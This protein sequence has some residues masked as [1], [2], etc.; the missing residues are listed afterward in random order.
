SLSVPSSPQKS[1]KVN[2]FVRFLIACIRD[3]KQLD[4]VPSCLTAFP[5]L[6]LE[7]YSHRSYLP[8]SGQSLSFNKPPFSDIKDT[9]GPSKA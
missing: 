8:F 9:E 2:R 6:K 3:E 7:A 5:P 1:V 4:W